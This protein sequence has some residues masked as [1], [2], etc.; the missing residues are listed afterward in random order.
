MVPFHRGGGANRK[1]VLAPFT[2][3]P[4]AQPSF[5][6]RTDRSNHTCSNVLVQSARLLRAEP[7]QPHNGDDEQRVQ[8]ANSFRCDLL[9]ARATTQACVNGLTCNQCQAANDNQVSSKRPMHLWRHAKHRIREGKGCAMILIVKKKKRIQKRT[10]WRVNLGQYATPRNDWTVF[11]VMKPA[12]GLA[13]RTQKKRQPGRLG[14]GH[15]LT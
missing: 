10:R 5:P 2:D 4:L 3:A 1:E 9:A 15:G 7:S 8:P 6:N 14:Q 12:Y 11:V 13:C